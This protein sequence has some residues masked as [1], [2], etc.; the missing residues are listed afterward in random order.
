[1][2]HSMRIDSSDDYLMNAADPMSMV[3]CSEAGGPT[4]GGL[5]NAGPRRSAKALTGIA[6]VLLDQKPA[7]QQAVATVLWQSCLSRI[8]DV[9]GPAG[10]RQ[11]TAEG[12]RRSLWIIGVAPGIGK[13]PSG[14]A[15]IPF[16]A[17][18]V[19]PARLLTIHTVASLRSS[20]SV[21]L[22]RPWRRAAG[23]WTSHV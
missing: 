6:D 4:A 11:R 13:A 18:A 2:C 14:V 17:R 7:T 16:A 8:M 21:C 20:F 15:R 3:G 12:R 9:A 1:M 10:C 19:S 23:F 5:G 22:S